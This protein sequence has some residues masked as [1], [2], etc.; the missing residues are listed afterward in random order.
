MKK[1]TRFKWLFFPEPPQ[2]PSEYNPIAS[3]NMVSP[4]LITKQQNLWLNSCAC[5]YQ[6]A[7]VVA[8]Q[9]RVPTKPVKAWL[10]QFSRTTLQSVQPLAGFLEAI[11]NASLECQMFETPFNREYQFASQRFRLLF[12]ELIDFEF[13]DPM[14]PGGLTQELKRQRA[15]I[16]GLRNYENP[17]REDSQPHWW[18]FIEDCRRRAELDEIFRRNIFMGTQR[19]SKVRTK[20]F[21]VA[22]RDWVDYQAANYTTSWLQGDRIIRQAG[23]GRSQEFISSFP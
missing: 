19:A 20:P 16:V 6:L 18:R 7:Y 17:Y 12:S 9:N 23:K 22:Y 5:H 14:T 1:N 21:L 8:V 4:R 3:P 11:L 10:S 2:L 13:A 15:E